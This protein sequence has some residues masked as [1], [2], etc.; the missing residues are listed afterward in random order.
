MSK[1]I[2]PGVQVALIGKKNC[3]GVLDFNQVEHNWCDLTFGILMEL[4]V[5]ESLPLV[6]EIALLKVYPS[7]KNKSL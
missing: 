1:F 3:E 7:L 6:V 5:H 4:L 2:R